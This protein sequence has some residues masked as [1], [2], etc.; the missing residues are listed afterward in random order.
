[1][2]L[3]PGAF[4]A[5]WLDAALVSAL[6]PLVTPLWLEPDW[7]EVEAVPVPVAP[8][9]LACDES[10]LGVPY[11]ELVAPW[12]DAVA[13]PLDGWLLMDPLVEPCAFVSVPVLLFALLAVEVVAVLPCAFA[14]VPAVEPV[15]STVP[16][17]PSFDDVRVLLLLLLQLK[18]SAATSARPYAYFISFLLKGFFAALSLGTPHEAP[19]NPR[20]LRRGRH[21]AAATEASWPP[22]WSRSGRARR[23]CARTLSEL[24]QYVQHGPTGTPGLSRLR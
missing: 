13:A 3:W 9:L 21:R 20:L 24:P 18:T 5:V 12:S 11:A 1:M 14:C 2:L 16:D 22:G 23:R 4:V 19:G 10:L 8:V 17:L 6:G 7:S 15:V